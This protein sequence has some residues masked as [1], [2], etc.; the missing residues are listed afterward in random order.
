MIAVWWFAST[1]LMIVAVA[2]TFHY[3]W[4]GLLPTWSALLL[5]FQW[6]S[7]V[8][9][10]PSAYYKDGGNGMWGRDVALW[11]GHASLW[12]LAAGLV[13][14]AWRMRKARLRTPIGKGSR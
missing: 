3:R 14:R 10:M 4:S 11:M 8:Y 6:T 2:V 9:A 12:T 1:L 13:A 7:A 5:F